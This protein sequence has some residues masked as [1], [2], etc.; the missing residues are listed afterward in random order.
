MLKHETKKYFRTTSGN[1]ALHTGKTLAE[2]KGMQDHVKVITGHGTHE[3]E[4]CCLRKK[5]PGAMQDG[6]VRP[7]YREAQHWQFSPR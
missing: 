4:R 1:T 6:P 3:L 5:S 2:N 7:R